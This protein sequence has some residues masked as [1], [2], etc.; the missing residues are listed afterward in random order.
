[1]TQHIWRHARR[2]LLIGAA[3][4]AA[5]AGVTVIGVFI[6]S[7]WYGL[8]FFKRG[9]MTW[10]GIAP[11][12]PRL[13]NSIRLAL[14]DN[15]PLATPGPVT[16]T[17][18]GDGFQTAELAARVND[19]EVDRIL[20]ARL[21]PEKYRF[22]VHNHPAGDRELGDWM[23]V[24]HATVVVNGS[25]FGHRGEPVTPLVSKGF[26]LGPREYDATHGAFV[27]SDDSVGIH[28]LHRENW[29]D[30]FKTARYG[31]VSYPLL[32]GPGDH[33]VKSGPRFLASRTFVGQDSAGFIILGTTKDG[34]F[35]LE[36]LARF[37]KDAPL[38]LTLALNLDGG[39]VACQGIS[40][41]GFTRDF[42]GKWEINDDGGELQLL[43]P[44]IG[45][46][47]AGLPIVL[48]ALPR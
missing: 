11:D 46:R 7:G 3:A 38:D 5:V 24:L 27:A 9:A 1:M 18:R 31:L 17:S 21:D 47:R 42:C 15:P 13:S 6:H 48:A 29:K 33:A 19:Q 22:Q 34:F 26:N 16:W 28:D 30:L 37:L 20:L 2:V 10:V 41:G 35:S 39:P 8:N 12:D 44:V 45:G 23:R 4:L 14:Q 43:R 40:I 36:R 25:Y 32:V